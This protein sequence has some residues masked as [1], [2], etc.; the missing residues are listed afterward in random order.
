MSR[1]IFNVQDPEFN[2]GAKG[3]GVTDDSRAFQ[4]ALDAIAQQSKRASDLDLPPPPPGNTIR[5]IE[6][7]GA[8]LFVPPGEYFLSQTLQI[9]RRIIIQGVGGM[10]GFPGSRLLFA[11]GVTGII[12]HRIFTSPAESDTDPPGGHGSG[13]QAG[14]GNVESPGDRSAWDGSDRPAALCRRS[15]GRGRR[16]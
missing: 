1:S 15:A 9:T 3:D 7:R 14:C 12:V 5:Q 4:L 8:I 10:G 16:R 6:A 11:P 2:G 13:D